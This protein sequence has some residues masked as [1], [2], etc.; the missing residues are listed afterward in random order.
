MSTKIQISPT[1]LLKLSEFTPLLKELIESPF[2]KENRCKTLSL[3]EISLLIFENTENKTSSPT[4]TSFKENY[5]LL[6]ETLSEAGYF[7]FPEG[8]IENL[9]SLIFTNREANPAISDQI[10]NEKNDFYKLYLYFRNLSPFPFS[11]ETRTKLEAQQLSLAIESIGQKFLHPLLAEWWPTREA[12]ISLV[13]DPESTQVHLHSELKIALERLALL[14]QDIL[15]EP[16]FPIF[17]I[18][19]S[20][21]YILSLENETDFNPL[22]LEVGYLLFFFGQEHFLE[23]FLHNSLGVTGIESD[24]IIDFSF[25]MIRTQRLKTK[26]FTL[27]ATLSPEELS[28]MQEDYEALKELLLKIESFSKKELSEAA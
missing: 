10:S 27:N 13:L 11:Q 8:K 17:T 6:L 26:A 2:S 24:E 7:E 22:P 18:E 12:A 9:A 25:R 23:K 5:I 15:I 1:E 14:H 28:S 4:F 20:L 3:S 19:N 21:K 16:Q